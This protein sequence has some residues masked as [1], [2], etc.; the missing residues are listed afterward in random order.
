MELLLCYICNNAA[1]LYQ[2][3]LYKTK[4]KHSGI[5]IW[6]FLV[7]LTKEKAEFSE[8]I[9]KAAAESLETRVVC[10]KCLQQID[11]YD[12]AC[13]TAQRIE[14]QL[15][16]LLIDTKL[17]HAYDPLNLQ[18]DEVRFPTSDAFHENME[19]TDF[20]FGGSPDVFVDEFV[21]FKNNVNKQSANMDQKESDGSEAESLLVE[22]KKPTRPPKFTCQKCFV[23]LRTKILFKV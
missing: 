10:A 14:K 11:E 20:V 8:Y 22:L 17:V 12:L 6:D 18:N 21:E 2:K 15:L 23:G 7:K 1:E 19:E 4:S 5:P 13:T 9:S 3:N 16:D